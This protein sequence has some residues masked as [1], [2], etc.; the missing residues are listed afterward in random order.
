MKLVPFGLS[1]KIVSF[2]L[3]HLLHIHCR[4]NDFEVSNLTSNFK[5][6][7]FISIVSMISEV[8]CERVFMEEAVFE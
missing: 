5:N 7:H 3:P 8:P 6:R 2:T 1:I 4:K